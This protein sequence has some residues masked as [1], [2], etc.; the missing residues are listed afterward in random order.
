[1][2]K[3]SVHLRL[4]CNP[5]WPRMLITKGAARPYARSTGPSITHRTAIPE[6]NRDES[7]RLT[8]RQ[9][10]HAPLPRRPTRSPGDSCTHRSAAFTTTTDRPP[11]APASPP[12]CCRRPV[13]AVPSTSPRTA[14]RW[15]TGYLG[16]GP[17]RHSPVVA[18][19][20]HIA[21]DRER[22]GSVATTRAA[23]M[24]PARRLW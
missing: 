3:G 13:P 21:R 23:S 19:R 12:T 8:R 7:G 2:I 15:R 1:M 10:V 18:Q 17:N 9:G 11:T 4:A 6:D 5:N 16:A 14:W 22:P 20:R 24:Q